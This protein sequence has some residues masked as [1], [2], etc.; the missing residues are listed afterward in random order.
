MRGYLLFLLCWAA[1]LCGW[2]LCLMLWA[3][4]RRT[5]SGASPSVSPEMRKKWGVFARFMT[6]QGRRA[7]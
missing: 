2:A 3:A 6:P 1:F 4:S 7:M 5:A